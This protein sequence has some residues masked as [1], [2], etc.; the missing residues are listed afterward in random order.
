MLLP[1]SNPPTAVLFE[2]GH[3]MFSVIGPFNVA[4]SASSVADEPDTGIDNA[5]INTS[6][7]VAAVGFVS[8]NVVAPLVPLFV[9]VGVPR[10]TGAAPTPP[11]VVSGTARYAA[12]TSPVTAP[13]GLVSATLA[14]PPAPLLALV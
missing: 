5:P 10:N 14:P 8:D 13:D 3:H 12:S 4:V 2:H 1:G 11:V 7:V 6:L 9:A